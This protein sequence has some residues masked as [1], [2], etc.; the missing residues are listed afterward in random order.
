M[1]NAEWINI[2]SRNALNCW[3]CRHCTLQM[4]ARVLRAFATAY[5][6]LSMSRFSSQRLN[7]QTARVDDLT[8]VQALHCGDVSLRYF[9]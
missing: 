4:Q 2:R 8:L 7:A 6:R 3:I 1:L 5:L 9:C